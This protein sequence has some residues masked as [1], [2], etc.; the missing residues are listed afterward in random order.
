M[1]CLESYTHQTWSRVQ[2]TDG[3][4][5][6]QDRCGGFPI[7]TALNMSGKT[8][9]KKKVYELKTTLF[10]QMSAEGFDSTYEQLGRVDWS[11]Q[12]INWDYPVRGT[13]GK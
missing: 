6:F 4:S 1:T 13:E 8:N 11:S 12:L 2:K 10:K 9:W 5:E 7:L 3:G